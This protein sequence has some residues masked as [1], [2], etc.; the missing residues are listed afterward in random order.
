MKETARRFSENK[1]IEVKANENDILLSN[2]KDFVSIKEGKAIY[3][4]SWQ[5]AGIDIT[6]DWVSKC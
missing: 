3:K 4:N 6:W 2:G 5:A 1:K